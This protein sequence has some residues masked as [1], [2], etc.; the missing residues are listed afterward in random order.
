VEERP[1]YSPQ[2]R[3][4]VLLTGSGTAGA[5]HAGALRALI[6]AG[7]KID[8]VA[9]H[10]SGMLTALAAAVDGGARVWDSS[11][12]WTDPRLRRAYTWRPAL[13]FAF[14]GFLAT[15]VVLLSP[16]VILAAAAVVYALATV[17]SLMSLTTTAQWLVASYRQMVEVLFDP[18]ILP[19][20]LPRALVLAVLVI[21]GVVAGAAGW[22]VWLERSRRRVS[23]AFWWRLI[24]SPL[25]AT[26]PA[27]MSLDTIWR[28][29]RGASS[30][31]RA[32]SAEVGRR[33]V[34]VLA[35]NFGQPGFHEVLVAVHDLDARQDLV[36]AILAAP[37]RAAFEGPRDDQAS[38]GA[39]IDLTG[40]QRETLAGFLVGAFRLPVVTE[41]ATVSF[42][43]DSYWRAERHRVCDRPELAVRLVE[44][45]ARL[46]VDQLVLVSPAAE[47]ARPST[48]RARPIDL[49]GRTGELVR[50]IET[51]AL[52]DAAALARSRCRSVFVV[53][54][55][56]NPIGPFDFG[57]VYD[58]ASDRRLTLAE[59]IEQGRVDA[60]RLVVEPAVAIEEYADGPGEL[61]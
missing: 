52:T 50:S 2:L 3:T 61:N 25:D 11:G 20:L 55:D 8:V 59:L 43:L 9:A 57:G 6:E 47:P 41:P 35:D 5:Y 34:D 46:G 4:G 45:I 42:P 16:L 51:A 39:F 49:R 48:M 13:R 56:H 15:V 29:V 7:I 27:A 10:G 31:S 1:V 54:P 53:R 12:P 33:Y 28:L 58:E 22:A 24:S 14:A 18:P 21:A 40:P 60:Y 26:E 38:D 19:T 32:P 17:A 30:E 23:G 37:S 36:G 44:E